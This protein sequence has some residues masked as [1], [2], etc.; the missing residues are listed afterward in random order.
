MERQGV[1]PDIAKNVIRTRTSVI[2]AVMVQRGEADAMLAGV[3][4]QYRTK[5]QHVLDVF[6]LAPGVHVPGSMSAL[7]SDE[8]TIFVCDTHVNADPDARQVAEVTLMAAEKLKIFGL[9][10]K[11]AL[12]SHSAFGSENDRT[13]VKMKEALAL[14]REW[15]PDL[16]VEGEMTADMALD[17]EFRRQV[18]PNSRLQGRANLLVAPDIASAHISFNLARMLS[19]SVTVGPILLGVGKPAH[20]LTSSATVRRVVNMTAIA[21]VD[22]QQHDKSRA[23]PTVAV[24]VNG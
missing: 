12:L 10:P 15:A 14:L 16:E 24:G 9:R 5:L 20:V 13:A 23:E 17:E 18:F 4:G 1:S 11:V 3:V 22:A 8:N 6:G 21:V 2:A 7:T 19:N